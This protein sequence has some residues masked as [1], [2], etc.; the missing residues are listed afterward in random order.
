M[1]IVVIWGLVAFLTLCFREQEN[2]YKALFDHSEGGS[3]LVAGIWWE[4]DD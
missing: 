1:V 2:H 3:I 4:T